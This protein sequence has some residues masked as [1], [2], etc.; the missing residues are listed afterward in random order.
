MPE[1]SKL[2][3]KAIRLQRERKIIPPG[4][5]VLVAFSGGV[6]S[7]VLTSALLELKRF[8]KIERLALAHFNHRL[9]DTAERDEEFCK[10]QADSLG[11][12]IFVGSED[13]GRIAREKKANLEETARELR[14]SFLRRIKEEKGFDLIA[15]AQHLNDLME[16][17]ILW[18][19]RGSGL[20]GILGF[21]PSEGDVVRP[22]FS[23]TRKEIE[24]YARAM[25][26]RW[27]EDPSNS[28]PTF[29]RNRIRRRVIPVLREINPSA[30]ESFYRL[31]R[32]V[33]LEHDFIK[34]E[35]ERL[36]EISGRGGC[37][38]VSRLRGGHP[39]IVSR[40]ISDFFSIKS[41]EKTRQVMRL[42]ERGGEVHIG[43][44]KKVVRKGK[45]LCLKKDK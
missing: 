38:E 7:G 8:F 19:I 43:E 34:S 20:E 12:E 17:V 1:K 30:E 4:S 9:R 18:L 29:V 21:S 16:T 28:D 41:F 44:G 33:E 2:L 39:A 27:V 32:V 15:T 13:V 45:L 37:L 5:K 42:L 24:E 26:L 35:Q 3:R 23:A 6:D 36:K 22:L 25:N 40:V 31:W 14:Y 11:L 10:K